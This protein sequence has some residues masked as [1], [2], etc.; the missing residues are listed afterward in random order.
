MGDA[1]GMARS[2]ILEEEG[3]GESIDGVCDAVGLVLADLTVQ[4]VPDGD[5]AETDQPERHRSFHGATYSNGRQLRRVIIAARFRRPCPEQATPQETRA[6][7]AAWAATGTCINKYCE[8]QGN[9]SG[10]RIRPWP[11]TS[12]FRLLVRSR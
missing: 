3:E 7:L 9:L 2:E 5:H 6:V 8:T 10:S 4:R 12:G 11:V 1:P